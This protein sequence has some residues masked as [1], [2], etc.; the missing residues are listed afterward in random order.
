M[1]GLTVCPYYQSSVHYSLGEC[2]KA[3]TDVSLQDVHYR[4]QVA[5]VRTHI[6]TS[7]RACISINSR[8]SYYGQTVCRGSR[9][10]H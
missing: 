2:K 8:T 3:S 6:V 4:L 10:L 5:E 7:L 9:G 1:A